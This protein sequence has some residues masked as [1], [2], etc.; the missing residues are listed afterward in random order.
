MLRCNDKY[1]FGWTMPSSA[2]K[3]KVIQGALNCGINLSTKFQSF[4]SHAFSRSP[5]IESYTVYRA[6]VTVLMPAPTSAV[7][8][9]ILLFD[10]SFPPP[11]SNTHVQVERRV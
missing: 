4:P 1:T 3:D 5:V 7:N 10:L 8:T 6:Y 2:I 11:F 9:I